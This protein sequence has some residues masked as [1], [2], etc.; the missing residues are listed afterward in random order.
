MIT[1]GCWKKFLIKNFS[2]CYKGTVAFLKKQRLFSTTTEETLK[3]SLKQELFEIYKRISLVE[4]EV[5]ESS[6]ERDAIKPIPAV[7]KN[8]LLISTPHT[9][10]K[11]QKNNKKHTK[12]ENSDN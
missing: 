7:T 6:F 1:N 12:I 9:F 8:F 3:R 4:K 2:Q 11:G 5:F 10:K